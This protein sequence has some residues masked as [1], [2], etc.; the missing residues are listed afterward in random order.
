LPARPSGAP[1]PPVIGAMKHPN[2]RSDVW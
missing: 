1:S 2:G